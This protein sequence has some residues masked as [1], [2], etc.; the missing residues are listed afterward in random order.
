MSMCVLECARIE[1]AA[2]GIGLE[3]VH[4][5]PS[6]TSNE[7]DGPSHQKVFACEELHVRI[8]SEATSVRYW[9]DVTHTHT[10]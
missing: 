5:H 7:L 2:C 6:R 10:L 1:L 3:V 4:P 9:N 8:A